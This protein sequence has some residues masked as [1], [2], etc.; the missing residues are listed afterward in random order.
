VS[1]RSG[2]DG[3]ELGLVRQDARAVLIGELAAHSIRAKKAKKA[4]D[5]APQ[6]SAVHAGLRKNA[7]KPVRIQGMDSYFAFFRTRASD[8]NR[9]AP[10]FFA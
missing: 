4:K 7:K 8:D 5:V 1:L 10:A 9:C 2:Q 3:H 6:A